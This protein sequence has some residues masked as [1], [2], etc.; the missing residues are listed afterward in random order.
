[1]GTK[2]LALILFAIIAILLMS[3][4]AGARANPAPLLP[5]PHDEPISTPPTIV[6]YSPVENQTYHSPSVLLNFSLVKPDSWYNGL[7]SP[8]FGNVTSVC[9]IVDNAD[10]VNI[11]VHDLASDWLAIPP[12]ATL[13]FSTLLNVTAGVHSLKIGVYATTYWVPAGSWSI[14]NVPLNETIESFNFNVELPKPNN[15][16]TESKIADALSPSVSS[17]VAL[18]VLSIVVA[19]ACTSII[20]YH[21]KKPKNKTKSA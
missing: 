12:N 16:S 13:S 15:K 8:I 2:N 4:L 9:Y 20:L 3:L 5:F 7:N 19:I 18:V 10:P 21:V 17:P 1:M 14:V 11:T 6:V